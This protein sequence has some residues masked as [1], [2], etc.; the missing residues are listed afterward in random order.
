MQGPLLSLSSQAVGL[1]QLALLLWR[2]GANNATD[3]YFYLWTL[4][5]LPTLTLI[6][7]VMYPMLL[8]NSRIGGPGV[9]RIAAVTPVMS[10]VTVAIGATWF[11]LNDR[12]VSVI[13]PIAIASAGNAAAQA[14]VWHRAVLSEAVGEPRWMCAVALP[15]NVLAVFVLALPLGSAVQVVTFMIAAL[16]VG[17]VGLYL[18]MVRLEVGA[19]AIRG[20]EDLLPATKATF[21][22]FFFRAGS[23]QLALVVIQSTAVLLPAATLTVVSVASKF[24]GAFSSIFVNALIPRFINQS[25][26]DAAAANKFILVLWCF[27]FPIGVLVTALALPLEGLQVSLALLGSVWVLVATTAAVAQRMAFRFLPASTSRLSIGAVSLVSLLAVMSASSSEFNAEML[28]AA[29]AG[30]D[31]LTGVMFLFMLRSRA[32]FVLMFGALL[33]VAIIWVG[34]YFY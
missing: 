5:M 33:V 6:V 7:G 32:A 31:A 29:Y 28:V 24:V 30:L 3:A 22:W 20:G 12:P 9:T 13:L 10:V 4:G 16:F 1:I 21:V 27:L 11:A 34:Q 17:N 23:G 2:T 15:S 18:A 25:T 19:S 26:K 14:L 8:N